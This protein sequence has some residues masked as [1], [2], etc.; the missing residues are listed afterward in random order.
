MT[1]REPVLIGLASL[2]ALVA[3]ALVAATQLG[4]L[5]LSGEQVAGVVA[6][7]VAV[8]GAV[9]AMV[10]SV[11]VP[12]DSYEADVVDALFTPVPYGDTR[13]DVRDGA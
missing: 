5:D 8:S 3:A 7:V 13:N 6:F 12:R 10:R 4:W 2:D 11:V 1:S 9:A